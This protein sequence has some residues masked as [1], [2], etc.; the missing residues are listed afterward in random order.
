MGSFTSLSITHLLDV[1]VKVQTLAISQS[2][3]IW[4]AWA[5]Q[6]FVILK[7]AADQHELMIL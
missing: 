1:K 5:Q 2:L 6:H 3:L 7:M 4:G